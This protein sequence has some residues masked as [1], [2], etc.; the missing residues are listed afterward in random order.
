[1]RIL[2]SLGLLFAAC[3]AVDSPTEATVD[4]APYYTRVCPASWVNTSPIAGQC[5][6]VQTGEK[7]TLFIP[8]SGA[9]T[10]RFVKR[11]GKSYPCRAANLSICSGN[12]CFYGP[13]GF[14]RPQVLEDVAI[15][16]RVVTDTDRRCAT[17]SAANS[18]D[19]VEFPDVTGTYPLS[20]GC[21]INGSGACCGTACDSC[22]GA[23]PPG[24]APAPSNGAG[25]WDVP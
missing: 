23:P 8:T 2:V 16:P 21:C 10:G 22:A 7:H 17:S 15:Y 3:T 13:N 4:D 18:W 12:A 25:E 9:N 1:M 6:T 20:C 5:C 24:N 11:I 19:P 14:A